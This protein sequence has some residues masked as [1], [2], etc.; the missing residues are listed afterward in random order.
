M[1]KIQN[2]NELKNLNKQDL[3]EEMLKGTIKGG[4]S[5]HGNNGTLMTVFGTDP[6]GGIT[7]FINDSIEP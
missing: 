6:M 3:V 1:K 5:C 7:L 4:S 2:L